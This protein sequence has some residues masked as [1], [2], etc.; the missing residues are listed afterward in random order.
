MQAENDAMNVLTEIRRFRTPSRVQASNRRSRADAGVRTGQSEQCDQIALE[1]DAELSTFIP[2]HA[3]YDWQRTCA[4][5]RILKDRLFRADPAKDGEQIA[6]T[7]TAIDAQ[8]PRFIPALE[9]KDLKG[10]YRSLASYRDLKTADPMEFPPLELLGYRKN[11]G[12]LD[13]QISPSVTM[14]APNRAK[15][16]ANL[17]EIDR[18]L[19]ALVPKGAYFNPLRQQLVDVVAG[20]PTIRDW[21]EREDQI[22]KMR[23]KSDS[24]DFIPNS[25]HYTVKQPVAQLK[26]AMDDVQ[27]R[28]CAV[29]GVPKRLT[30]GVA[31]GIG[32]KI[33]AYYMAMTPHHADDK[34]RV[35]PLVAWLRKSPATA[36]PPDPVPQQVPTGIRRAVSRE[37]PF[38][39]PVPDHIQSAANA[40][41]TRL[42]AVITPNRTNFSYR[43]RFLQ[44]M[45]YHRKAFLGQ[46]VDDAAGS[47]GTFKHQHYWQFKKE[48]QIQAL[49]G[50]LD[51]Y[52]KAWSQ[53][54]RQEMSNAATP[55]GANRPSSSKPDRAAQ[56]RARSQD[57]SLDEERP[58]KQARLEADAQ[59]TSPE[60]N[61]R[62]HERARARQHGNEL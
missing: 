36:R 53:P 54:D 58:G 7:L 50:A 37:T 27:S 26:A 1:I 45:S 18:Q 39:S 23:E 40:V 9:A 49:A 13:H 4:L 41:L 56:K 25:A 30:P 31:I 43:T 61:S 62:Y 21:M 16:R 34:P 32:T 28:I 52:H 55:D 5:D 10:L 42:D 20:N 38:P 2:S 15:F 24:P 35:A 60:N 6:A 22:A 11:G 51:G 3:A 44:K 57:G 19:D 29:A 47:L 14:Q 48:D 8:A 33:Q 59:P 46:D 17:T 12:E